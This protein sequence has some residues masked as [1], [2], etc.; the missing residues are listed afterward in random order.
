MHER[1]FSVPWGLLLQMTGIQ[2]AGKILLKSEVY[3]PGPM[4]HREE[5]MA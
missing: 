3:Y 4:P 2:V 5:L 1:K